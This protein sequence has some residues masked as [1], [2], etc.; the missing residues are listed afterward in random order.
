LGPGLFFSFVIFFTQMVGLLGWVI[1]QS[2]GH[3]LNTGQHKQNKPIHRHLCLE[4]D[5]NPQSQNSS[6]RRQ[7]MPYSAQPPWSAWKKLY[8][9]NLNILGSSSSTTVVRLIR[10]WQA[11]HISF[12]HKENKEWI[13]LEVGNSVREGQLES[14]TWK[15]NAGMHFYKICY[16][17]MDLIY[18]A[19]DR[20]KLHDFCQ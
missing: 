19:E 20:I 7:F 12:L 9:E 3:Y 1:S 5:S 17:D 2:Q 14:G 8:S 10:F 18:L 11:G 16:E 13:H 4:W 6:E 15:D